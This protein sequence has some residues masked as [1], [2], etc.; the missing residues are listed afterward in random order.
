MSQKVRQF[1]CPNP[2]SEKAKKR[3]KSTYQQKP[4]YKYN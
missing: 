4:G 2:F 3:G 1:P